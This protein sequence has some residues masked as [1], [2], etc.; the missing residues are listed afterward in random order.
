MEIN[1]ITNTEWR[2]IKK[3]NRKAQN[4]GTLQISHRFEDGRRL[5]AFP[6]RKVRNNRTFY[7]L[8]I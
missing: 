1:P 3:K 4:K 2:F 6:G 7:L 8:N 5:G